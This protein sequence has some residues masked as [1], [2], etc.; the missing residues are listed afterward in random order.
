MWL[1]R[2][3]RQVEFQHRDGT[4]ALKPPPR[5]SLA[6]TGSGGRAAGGRAADDSGGAGGRDAR[7]VQ[8]VARSG[9]HRARLPSLLP[10]GALLHGGHVGTCTGDAGRD[11]RKRSALLSG[12]DVATAVA[13]GALFGARWRQV[14]CRELGVFA[15]A[16]AERQRRRRADVCAVDL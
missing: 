7:V 14:K 6:Y 1:S 10:P 13:A 8:G 11:V 9:S 2:V 12:S 3:S 4:N 15:P 5:L 16:A